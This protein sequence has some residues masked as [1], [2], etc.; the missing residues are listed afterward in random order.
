MPERCIPS[1]LVGAGV[2]SDSGG[3]DCD[4]DGDYD[5]DSDGDGK[6]SNGADGGWCWERPWW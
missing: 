6:T 2:G 4:N 5:G 3:D 1:Q